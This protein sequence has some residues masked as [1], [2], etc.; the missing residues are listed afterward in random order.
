[1]A[2]QAIVAPM[3]YVDV[4]GARLWFEEDDDGGNRDGV[5]YT[6]AEVAVESEELIRVA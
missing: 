5:T 3:P 6:G 1:M 4:N 2:R